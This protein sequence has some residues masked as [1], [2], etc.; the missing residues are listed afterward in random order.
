MSTEG[1]ENRE[2]FLRNYLGGSAKSH[3]LVVALFVLGL[4]IAAIVTQ[5]LIPGA[6]LVSVGSVATAIVIAGKLE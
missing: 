2:R 4:G 5:H 1:E 6:L 3:A